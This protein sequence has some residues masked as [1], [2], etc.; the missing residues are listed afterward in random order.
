M[1]TMTPKKILSLPVYGSGTTL[2]LIAAIL[3]LPGGL[4]M[5]FALGCYWL[6]DRLSNDDDKEYH[7]DMTVEEF[8]KDI[9][10][11]PFVEFVK[12][13]EPGFKFTLQECSNCAYTDA[14]LTADD[15]WCGRWEK[16]IDT[17]MG[18]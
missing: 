14:C 18:A 10:P 17:R 12:H 1:I 9:I 16:D 5:A 6:A 13:I 4:I 11:V 2:G 8:E 7:C 3:L 15:D